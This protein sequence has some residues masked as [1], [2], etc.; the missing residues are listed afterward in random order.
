[1][2]SCTECILKLYY[3]LIYSLFSNFL[4][5]TQETS[6]FF[7]KI[8]WSLVDLLIGFEPGWSYDNLSKKKEW[9]NLAGFPRNSWIFSRSKQLPIY[10]HVPWRARYI[11]V[12]MY[13]TYIYIYVRS[14]S[15]NV[16][17]YDWVLACD[18]S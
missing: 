9:I 16:V 12:Y 2:N 7:F 14:I 3:I 13:N 10:F 1:M 15:F 6:C 4:E 5:G 17:P 18:V 11:Y 8:F